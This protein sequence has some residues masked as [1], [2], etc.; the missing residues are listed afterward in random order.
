M[1][2]EKQ[3]KKRELRRFLRSALF[4]VLR[5]RQKCRHVITTVEQL[6]VQVSNGLTR[7]K[8]WKRRDD[9]MPVPFNGQRSRSSLWYSLSFSPPVSPR[10][11]KSSSSS[12]LP[13]H[14]IESQFD[15]SSKYSLFVEKIPL[16]SS[17]CT[18]LHWNSLLKSVWVS[19]RSAFCSHK[20]LTTTYIFQEE[21]D[22]IHIRSSPTK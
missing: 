6:R 10:K 1:V 2:T 5:R 3:K 18:R 8:T 12:P 17:A 22:N 9:V 14:L 13:T 7:T 15:W 11:H 19:Q 4:S 21:K 16:L 20:K